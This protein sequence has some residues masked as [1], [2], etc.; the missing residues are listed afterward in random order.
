MKCLK[1]GH[2]WKR[3]KWTEYA[4]FLAKCPKCGSRFLLRY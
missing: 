2:T 3:T 4:S 1:C